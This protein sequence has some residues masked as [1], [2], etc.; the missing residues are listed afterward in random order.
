MITCCPLGRI[1]LGFPASESASTFPTMTPWPVAIADAS[2]GSF[3]LLDA[4]WMLV[5]ASG[6]SSGLP[7]DA[8]HNCC[9]SAAVAGMVGFRSREAA[10]VF[11]VD[12]ASPMMMVPS[13]TTALTPWVRLSARASAAG[14]VAATALR[15]E[16]AVICVAP[17]CFNWAT[18]GACMD[19]AVASL[20][21]SWARFAGRPVSWL[22]NTTTM[23]SRLPDER[24]F[25]WLGLNLEKLDGVGCGAAAT[26]SAAAVSAAAAVK[27]IASPTAPVTA[28]NRAV[29]MIS[30][31]L[32]QIAVEC[33]L[34]SGSVPDPSDGHRQTQSVIHTY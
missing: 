10:T 24:A 9:P 5:R 34:A 17:T 26:V 28:H 22:S 1:R 33:P 11:V 14:I 13:G 27:D 8:L 32:S 23:G 31:Y 6:S 3:G 29:F 30:P 20:A 4:S 16:R 2:F 21:C 19:A 25:T 18:S 15:S 7:G 12:V